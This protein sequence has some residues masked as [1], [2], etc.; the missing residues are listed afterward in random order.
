MSAT[1][2]SG[3]LPM[4]I[5]TRSPGPTPRAR[6]S[7]AA[8]QAW[9]AYRAVEGDDGGRGPPT[10]RRSGA[11]PSAPR[12]VTV[13]RNRP[14]IVSGGWHGRRHVIHSHRWAIDGGQRGELRIGSG[15]LRR[16]GEEWRQFVPRRSLGRR[17][18][19]GFSTPTSLGT[20][21]RPTQGSASPSTGAN[22]DRRACSAH[23]Q[24]S[25]VRWSAC[26][27]SRQVPRSPRSRRPPPR[28]RR[29]PPLPRRARPRARPR[30]PPL[31]RRP[32]RSR[33]RMPSPPSPTR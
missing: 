1:W 16:S 6:S 9:S 27:S 28:R 29:P 7:A 4:S 18:V 13:R 26:S 14:G 24:W 30:P 12:S 10:L 20:N 23:A 15:K 17:H 31:R 21:S 5:T 19:A 33:I 3:R 32:C 2:N 25:R 22:A 8:R 11:R